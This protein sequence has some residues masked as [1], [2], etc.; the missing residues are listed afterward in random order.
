MFC[1]GLHKNNWDLA[2]VSIQDNNTIQSSSVSVIP[3]ERWRDP[4]RAP[5]I[6]V[7]SIS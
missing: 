2:I 3:A 7:I 4:I 6:L 1:A 5:N